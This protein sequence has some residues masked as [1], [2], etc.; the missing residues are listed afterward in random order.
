M[1]NLK[2]KKAILYRRVSTTDQKI[3][4]NSLNAQ[5]DRLR[6][7]C[8]DNG[9]SIIKEFEEEK[10]VIFINLGQNKISL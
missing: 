10:S 6:S 4:G 9:I 5:K 2:N 1:K 8:N 3:H 7:F